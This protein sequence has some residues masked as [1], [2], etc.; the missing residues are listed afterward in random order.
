MSE[1]VADEGIAVPDVEPPTGLR[2]PWVVFLLPFGLFMV[3]TQFEPK[4]P[5]L[6]FNWAESESVGADGLSEADRLRDEDPAYQEYV[7]K[8]P[9]VY[10]AKVVVVTLAV[11]LVAPGYRT[12][13]WRLTWLGPAVGLVG[14]VVWV[15]LCNWNLEDKLLGPLGITMFAE[16]G[17]RSAFNPLEALREN[18]AWAYTFLVIRFFGLAVLVPV[19]EEVFLRG[20]LMRYVVEERWWAVPFG[21]ATRG[22]IIAGTAFPMLMHPGELLAAFA[23]FSMV[24]W[25]MLRTKSLGDCVVAHAVTNLLLG[26]Y[27]LQTG[28]WEL[29]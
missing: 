28:S 13:P 4:P 1:T 14:I 22:A 17:Q 29:W 7:R 5:D 10:T 25:M 21:V 9:L 20:F 8:Y 19:I 23:W 27:V 11:L 18:P 3:F 6:N 24:T 2:S 12:V 16:A 26:F 15:V